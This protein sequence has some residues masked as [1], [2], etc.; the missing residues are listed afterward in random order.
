MII[1]NSSTHLYYKTLKVL[2][3]LLSHTLIFD[4]IEKQKA[5]VSHHFINTG[6]QMQSQV[7]CVPNHRERACRKTGFSIYSNAIFREIEVYITIF[8]KFRSSV[9]VAS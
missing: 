1:L 6:C 7:E 3:S 5:G 4:I 2:T 9:S 8:R